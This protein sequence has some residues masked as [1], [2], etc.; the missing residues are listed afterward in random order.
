MFNAYPTIANKTTFSFKKHHY[1]LDDFYMINY[2]PEIDKYST[3][4]LK[5]R[6]DKGTFIASVAIEKL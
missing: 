4:N 2:K 3:S 6:D 5:C 1:I